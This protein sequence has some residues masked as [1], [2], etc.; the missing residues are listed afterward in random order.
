MNV[1]SAATAHS[2]WVSK[3]TIR[4]I[5]IISSTC[6]WD[7]R[8]LF[9]KMS[10]WLF[11]ISRLPFLLLL[12]SDWFVWSCL[13]RAPAHCTTPNCWLQY[14]S[15]WQIVL[16]ALKLTWQTSVCCWKLQMKSCKSF[17]GIISCSCCV[18]ISS[19]LTFR[20]AGLITLALKSMWSVTSKA[21]SPRHTEHTSQELIHRAV[22]VHL[23]VRFFQNKVLS[24]KNMTKRVYINYKHST[25]RLCLLD[26]S[27]Y[28][29]VP[30][31]SWG[32]SSFPLVLNTQK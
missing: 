9:L 28:L 16:K 3:S 2:M 32:F 21:C 29:W 8:N 25:K 23:Y 13:C 20:K 31:V 19:W 5:K 17:F 4:L 15:H 24:F 30:F 7:F 1:T 11:K 27:I 12:F 22:K 6:L 10:K 26:Q 18:G 14:C